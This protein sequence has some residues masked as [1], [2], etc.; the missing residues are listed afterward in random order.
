MQSIDIVSCLSDLRGNSSG[1][2]AVGFLPDRNH[3]NGIQAVA[4][5]GRLKSSQPQFAQS[6][7]LATG[8]SIDFVDRL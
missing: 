1:T 4:L 8:Q 6:L 3:V 5:A 2:G 7:L